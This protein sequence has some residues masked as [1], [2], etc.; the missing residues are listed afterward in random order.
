MC[1]VSQRGKNEPCNN[2]Q[3][4]GNYFCHGSAWEK[5]V[6]IEYFEKNGEL[7]FSQDAGVRIHGGG[8][9]AAAQKSLRLYAREKY[10]KKYF[11]CRLLPGRNVDKYKRFILRTTM[12]AWGAPTV[13]KDVLAHAIAKNLDVD[14]Q[15]YSPVIVFINGEYWGI[16]TIRDRID[17]RYIEYLYNIDKDSVMFY[18]DNQ[19]DFF[20]ILKYID[21][22]DLADDSNY[23]Y[24]KERI[25]IDNYIDYNIIELFLK[26]FDW[27]VG[28]F[29]I[30]R[31]IAKG[32]KWRWIFFDLDGALGKPRDYNMLQHATLNDSSVV[33]PNPP[34]ST[35]L[36]RN[37]LKNRT[38]RSNFISRYSELLNMEFKSYIMISKLNDIEELYAPEIKS[39]AIRWHY[40]ES[41]KK[42]KE[43][44]E[45]ELRRFLVERPCYVA[46]NI[47]TFFNTD[48]FGFSCD[49][50]IEKKQLDI[51]SLLLIAPNPSDGN[52]YFYN[53][54][55]YILNAEIIISNVN[56]SIV[57]REEN[58]FI[59]LG[60]LKYFNLS[61]L[62][63]NIYF[64]RIISENLNKQ[65]KIL[66]FH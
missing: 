43:A 44:V 17:E 42:W 66:I 5:P 47:M 1:F 53:N 62:P 56:G 39:H 31:P 4:T 11:K 30:W 34:A 23:E 38:F 10:G 60:Y 14:Y 41:F 29:K 37:L 18:E 22:H 48:D 45:D 40:P 9:R 12:G 33:W 55:D 46:E 8:T 51:N 35:F 58:V 54:F 59:P 63:D 65:F 20:S 16:H 6:H 52:F 32:G 13:I 49:S 15:E 24:V 2:P 64:L 19:S 7:V 21:S 36:F 50:V 25:D 61:R 26:N 27:P 3:W 28:N 57:Y